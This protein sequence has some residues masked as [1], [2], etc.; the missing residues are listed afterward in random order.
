M[1]I[2]PAILCIF[3]LLIH[4]YVHTYVHTIS[5][6]CCIISRSCGKFLRYAAVASLKGVAKYMCQWC[7]RMQSKKPAQIVVFVFYKKEF[8]AVVFNNA[9]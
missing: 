9:Q 8:V 5:T 2:V 7:S 1:F 6:A 4:F 3:L